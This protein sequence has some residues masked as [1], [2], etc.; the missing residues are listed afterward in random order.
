MTP[1]PLMTADELLE[2]QPPDK[3]TDLISGRM[4]RRCAARICLRHAPDTRPELIA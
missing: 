4:V 2:L 1:V 3:Q